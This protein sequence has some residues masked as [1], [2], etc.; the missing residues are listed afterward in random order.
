[1]PKVTFDT[2][3]PIQFMIRICVLTGFSKT[4]C[5]R[6]TIAYTCS[7]HRRWIYTS[8]SSL[9]MCPVFIAITFRKRDGRAL[10]FQ[11]TSY[12]VRKKT[13][14]DFLSVLLSFCWHKKSEG[15]KCDKP[16]MLYG[17]S[18]DAKPITA[19]R[20]S[21]VVNEARRDGTLARSPLSY[22]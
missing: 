11:M 13:I 21:K 5:R 7:S 14:S 9:V 2:I 8:L 1:M 18:T 20:Q 6:D 4:V 3:T 10:G 17:V 22:I 19:W 16:H 15:W 12:F